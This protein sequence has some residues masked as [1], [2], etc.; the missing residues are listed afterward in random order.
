MKVSYSEDK[1]K[2]VTI[3][4]IDGEVDVYTSISLKKELNKLLED[5]K[6]RLL[7]NLEKV[8]YMDSSGLGVLVAMLKKSRKEKGNLKI[9]NLT[10]S[11]RK[12]FELTRLNKFFEIFNTEAEGLKSFD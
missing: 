7:I 10:E 1:K 11:I 12:I 9:T 4:K 8:S 3:V 5:N 6:N 2:K